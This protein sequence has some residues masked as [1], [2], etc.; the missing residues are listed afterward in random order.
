MTEPDLS[1]A[2][3]VYRRMLRFLPSDFH[4]EYGE[5]MTLLFED[6]LQGAPGVRRKSVFVLR[7]YVA[8]WVVAAFEWWAALRPRT[9]RSLLRSHL[10]GDLRFALRSLGR[11]P[12]FAVTVVLLVGLG[13]GA[14]TT[15]FT[16]FDHALLRPLPYPD[17]DRLMFVGDGAIRRASEAHSGPVLRAME[18]LNTIDARAIAQSEDAN[19][20]G[21]GD[22]LRV[23]SAQIS[24]EFFDAF[25]AQATHGRLLIAEDFTVPN[26]AVLSFGS[27]E[28]LF[29][30]DP[31]VVGSEIRLDGS[32]MTVVGILAGDFDPPRAL[33]DG[34]VDVWIPMDWRAEELGRIDSESFE[35]VVRLAEGVSPAVAQA[36]FDR[37]A[38]SFADLHPDRFVED[39]GTTTPLPLVPLQEATVQRV[40]GG[41]TLLLGAVGVLLLVACLNVAHLFLARAVGR[42]H[43]MEIRRALGAGLGDLVRQMLAESLVLGALGGLLGLGLAVL[44]LDT[45]L[46]LLPQ[47]LPIRSDLGIDLRILCFASVLTVGTAVLFGLVPALRFARSGDLS[48]LRGARGA[49]A[50]RGATR[51]RNA[52]V[53]GEVALSLMLVAQAGV[54]AK[55]LL[56]VVTNEPGLQPNQV[57]TI[58]LSS[59]DGS[60]GGRI[61]EVMEPVLAALDAVPGVESATFGLTLP[62]EYTGGRRAGWNNDVHW[63]IGSDPQVVEDVRYHPI[64]PSYFET[65]GVPLVAGE[66]WSRGDGQSADAL[67]PIVINERLATRLFGRP[68]DAVGRIVGPGDDPR[69]QRRITGVAGN[70][71]Y[72]GLDQPV[73]FEM[74]MPAFTIPRGFERA[75]V[76]VRVAGRSGTTLQQDLRQA[77]WDAAPELPVPIVRSMREWI[78]ASTTVRRFDSAIFSLFGITALLLAAAGLQG[79]LLF[80]VRQRRRELGIRMALG[81]TPGSVER[82]VIGD[83][84][85]LAALGSLTGLGLTLWNSRF[86]ESRLHEVAALDPM[87]LAAATLSLLTCAALASWAPARR[88]GSVDPL[89]ALRAE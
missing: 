5:E 20:L 44:G 18:S 54:L 74:F 21:L 47:D 87:P 88:A 19:L 49:S 57:W 24:A 65:L 89:E 63:T 62:F 52:L 40:R 80:H 30:G 75:H 45:L 16:V 35:V 42:V 43:E 25:G 17:T 39:D 64:S 46:A 7:S 10:G 68:Q 86:L 26:A 6:L 84:L 55:S 28:R 60:F 37:L 51:I 1:W 12:S 70:V 50:N 56:G 85:R 36:G 48:G 4:D 69:A 27:W 66:V 34:H 13:I 32:V 3:R 72:F 81:D 58:P 59:A 31:A 22:P 33:V 41:L 38:D 9:G 15:V 71:R 67:L 83:G 78:D 14:V 77:V 76:A 82:R 29:G 61:P 53:V 2:T 11:A 79:T 23:S 73:P 8:L